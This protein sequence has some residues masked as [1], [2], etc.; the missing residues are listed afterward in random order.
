MTPV[1]K[2]GSDFRPRKSTPAL[3]FIHVQH[4]EA[5]EIAVARSV[6]Y[7]SLVFL[8]GGVFLFICLSCLFLSISA[9]WLAV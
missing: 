2:V 3:D 8:E 9:K 5:T 1:P 4:L 7:I 6:P